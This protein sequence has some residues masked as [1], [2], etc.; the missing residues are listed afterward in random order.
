MI[1]AD[2]NFHAS[3]ETLT[4]LAGAGVPGIVIA[5]IVAIVLMACFFY[6]IT[7]KRDVG[8]ETTL[9]DAETRRN[10]SIQSLAASIR[11]FCEMVD[12][13]IEKMRNDVEAMS[14]KLDQIGRAHV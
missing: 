1:F 12:E 4:G 11:D 9:L 14:D 8:R 7:Y 10:E 6:W 5:L 3:T 13:K 2:S